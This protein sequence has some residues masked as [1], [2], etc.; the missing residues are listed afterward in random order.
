MAIDPGSWKPAYVQLAEILR[1]GILGG[2]YLPGGQL[3]SEMQLR[4]EYGVARGTIRQAVAALR[5]EGL[6][7]TRHAEGTFVTETAEPEVIAVGAGA[8]VRARMPTPEE[9]RALAVR[10]GIPV[11]V[12][13]DRG[14]LTV[15]AADEVIL[16]FR[17]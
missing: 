7:E 16:E 2:V 12:I 15:R 8:R 13:E 6:V 17:G 5:A 10:E 9:R 3:P 11:L 14:A 4:G 1:R